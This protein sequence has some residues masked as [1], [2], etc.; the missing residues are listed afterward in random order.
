MI[1][2]GNPAGAILCFYFRGY[3]VHL[4]GQRS[5]VCVT[6][7]DCFSPPIHGGVPMFSGRNPVCL[8]GIE[9]MLGVVENQNPSFFRKL[10]VSRINRK[11]S[12]REVFRTS[13]TWK[14]HVFPHES[15][16]MRPGISAKL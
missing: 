10:S 7:A 8:P 16:H 2:Q 15:N 6:E 3:T 11:I 14:I 4:A 13:V 1:S 12:S 9:K 5:A